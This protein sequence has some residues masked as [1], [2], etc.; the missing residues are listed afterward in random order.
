MSLANFSTRSLS[1]TFINE[2]NL[3]GFFVGSQ[4]DLLR[5]AQETRFALD[6]VSSLIQMGGLDEVHGTSW[7]DKFYRKLSNKCCDIWTFHVYERDLPAV[8]GALYKRTKRLGQYGPVWVTEFADT[9][10]GSP[11][12]KMNF[13]TREAALGFSELLGKLWPS[14]IDGIIHFRLSDTYAD[15]FGGWVGHGLFSDSRGTL[16]YG[17]PYEPYPAYWVFSNFYRE[18]G[19]KQLVR[20]TAPKKLTVVAARKANNSTNQLTVWV[21]NYTKNNYNILLRIANFP[22]MSACVEVIDNLAGDTPIENNVIEGEELTL[23][24][25]ILEKKS[26]SFLVSAVVSEH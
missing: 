19:G 10:N 1:F 8:W 6:E 16:T 2:P 23:K 9:K 15:Y 21:S 13:S 18:L 25:N 7:T 4:K 3:K 14:G 22:S 17:R 20:V 24:V 12:A 5:M 26:L 11:N